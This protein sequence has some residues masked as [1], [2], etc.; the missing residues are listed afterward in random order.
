MGFFDSIPY[1]SHI[2]CC[3]KVR[4]A[5]ITL[6]IISLF[7]RVFYYCFYGEGP[8]E[9]Y[10]SKM[11][12]ISMFI[13]EVMI[14]SA[15]TVADVLLL[16]GAINRN[17]EYLRKYLVLILGVMIISFTFNLY[18]LINHYIFIH[19]DTYFMFYFGFFVYD[20]WSWLC[21]NSL[22]RRLK[23]MD[24]ASIPVEEISTQLD[25]ITD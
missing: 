18:V 9:E 3:I 22:N 14:D 5:C 20:I 17:Q 24:V 23:S 6:A 1:C 16:I 13:L 19:K 25:S 11:Q 7:C 15:A 12:Q 8:F 2:C 4:A 10:E 21:A